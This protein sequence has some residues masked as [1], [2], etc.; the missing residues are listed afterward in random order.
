MGKTPR[1]EPFLGFQRTFIFPSQFPAISSP[2]G[3]D[4]ES[5]RGPDSSPKHWATETMCFLASRP[6]WCMCFAE[7]EFWFLPLKYQQQNDLYIY[8]FFKR[9]YNL[10]P[11]KSSLVMVD[12]SA[13]S[14][15]NNPKN[16]MCKP[17]IRCRARSR[18][19]PR[20]VRCTPRTAIRRPWPW[21]PPGLGHCGTK[22][23]QKMSGE[24]W[25]F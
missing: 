13:L 21:P 9:E 19:R 1:P 10:N 25:I 23:G 20:C 3:S 24:S 18:S 12:L 14:Y 16:E 15:P 22:P 4:S 2:L 11:L 8:I 6:I 7:F 5:H 17:S